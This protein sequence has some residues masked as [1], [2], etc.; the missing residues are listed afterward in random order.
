MGI[1]LEILRRYSPGRLLDI[2]TGHGLFARLAADCGWE[3]TAVDARETRFPDDA[4]VRWVHE[5]VRTFDVSGYDV[6]SCLGLWYHLTLDDQL[7]IL[8]R[9]KGTPII[10]DTHFALPR[11]QDHGKTRNVLTRRL[12]TDRGY[13]GRLYDESEL[14]DRS[15]ASFHN[16]Q[17]FWPTEVSLRAAL[18]S[19][20]YDIV[21]DVRPDVGPDRRFFVGTPIDEGRGKRLD[22]LI[23]TYMGPAQR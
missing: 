5:D 21:E 13:E 23:G 18:R 14:Q 19:A 3:V 17:S 6:L 7:D 22:E 9:A 11:W 4:R 1:F 12:V 2:G 10:I 15:T 20:G 16:V 8:R